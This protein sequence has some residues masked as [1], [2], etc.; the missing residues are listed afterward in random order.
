MVRDPRAVVASYKKWRN[1]GGLPGA[2]DPAH[3]AKLATE[4]ERTRQSYHPILPCAP[5]ARAGQ[6]RRPQRCVVMDPSAV[7]V[8]RY[9]DMVRSPGGDH[10]AMAEW[11]GVDFSAE[12]L[13][14]PMH[15]SSFSTFDRAEGSRRKRSDDGVTSW[16]P[17][18]SLSFSASVRGVMDPTATGGADRRRA[19]AAASRPVRHL[20][21]RVESRLFEPTTTE[22]AALPSYLARR[23]KA[24]W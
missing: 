2:D 10:D 9:E 22:A 3:E 4:A 18:R 14:V 20:P 13:D 8:Q 5:V 21:R 6:R 15:N 7:R 17:R 24:L 19:A 23:V 11:L 12:M 1:Q 16:R